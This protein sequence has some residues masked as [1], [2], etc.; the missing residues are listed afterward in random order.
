MPSIFI[1]YSRRRE[2]VVQTL[3][4]DLEGLGHTVWYDKEL[5]GGKPWW[6]GILAQIRS[7]EVFVLAVSPETLD[8]KACKR[9]WRYAADLGKIILP[10][11]VTPDVTPDALPVRLQTIQSVDYRKLDRAAAIGLAHA[12]SKLPPSPP[13]PDPLPAA[14]E[15]PIS[16]LAT[17]RDMIESDL[18]LTQQQ[19]T[20]IVAKLRRLA[21]ES[22]TRVDAINLLRALKVRS[23]LFADTDDDIEELL[24]SVPD[25]PVPRAAAA[26]SSVSQERPPT[27]SAITWW[28]RFRFALVGAI[29]GGIYGFAAMIYGISI[30]TNH[31]FRD[32]MLIAV[33][34]P[35]A[36]AAFV[37]LLSAGRRYL[38]LWALAGGLLPLV[39]SGPAGF[40]LIFA[41]AVLQPLGWV[42][43]V[44]LGAFVRM[45]IPVRKA[46]EPVQQTRSL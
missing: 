45:L 27:A 9:E 43:G 24:K 11:L 17:L 31:Q 21:R 35:S 19:Q 44:V 20:E 15:V 46:A 10:V 42:A 4:G 3:I 7:C 2:A 26:A 28:R 16:D 33:F 23:D 38:L 30:S 37:G 1:S 14:P 36:A 29:L 13:L 22:A 25:Q 41:F 34:A 32:E 5:T 6:D 12:F 18:A 8:S 40:S 39:G